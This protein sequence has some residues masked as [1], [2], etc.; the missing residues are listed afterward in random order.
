MCMFPLTEEKM[1]YTC[2]VTINL[3]RDRVLELFD[4]TENLKKWQNGLKAF[5]H[6]E[7]EPGQQGAKSK[8]I[9]DMNGREIE[10]IETVINRDL[11]D[12]LSFAY[13]SKGVWNSCVNLF[14][15]LSPDATEWRMDNEFRCKGLMKLMTALAP[16]MFKRQTMK[17]MSRFKDFAEN[18]SAR[19]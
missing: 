5:E 19:F 2:D 10:M 17:D 4:S 16:G 1:K 11:P 13:E 6:L 9:Y 8:L 7:G 14:N 3:P 15:D 12:E 18:S